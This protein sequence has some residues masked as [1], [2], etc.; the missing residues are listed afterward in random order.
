MAH[1]LARKLGMTRVFTEDGTALAVTVLEAGP[2][3]VTQVKTTETD[4]YQA[5]Q[6]GFGK[7]KHL[8]QPGQGHQS[9]AKTDHKW[10]REFRV[11]GTE[12]PAVG[13]A[14]TVDTFEPGMTISMA[15]TSKGKGFAGTVKR[16]GF[17]KGPETHGS[18]HHRQPG[19]IGSGYPERVFPG[20]RM[21]GHMGYER[22]TVRRAVVQAIHADKNLLVV[23]GPVPGPAKGLVSIVSLPVRQA[24]V[25]VKAKA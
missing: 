20:L 4:G 25:E 14:V 9:K 22:V 13:D 16:H 15:A 7:A 1:I 23:T 24:G 8:S 21:S 3:T 5:V 11:E 18:D 10:L 17:K 12:L 2:C 6:I 19:A